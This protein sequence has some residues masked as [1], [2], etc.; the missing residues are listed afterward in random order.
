MNDFS[1]PSRLYDRLY[2]FAL[3]DCA[4]KIARTSPVRSA[5]FFDRYIVPFV[6]L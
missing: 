3:F 5:N 4:E 6:K 1:P 2:D